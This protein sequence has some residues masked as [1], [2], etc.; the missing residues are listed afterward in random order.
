MWVK[1]STLKLGE[2][3]ERV[4]CVCVCVAAVSLHY[5]GGAA[6]NPP[7]LV[8]VFC[9]FLLLVFFR[10]PVRV[11]CWFPVPGSVG[12]FCIAWFVLKTV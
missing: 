8:P 10:F 11:F 6:E 12:F 3:D 9:W 1:R 7:F 2:L 4:L 5:P